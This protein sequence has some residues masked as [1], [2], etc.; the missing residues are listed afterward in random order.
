[1]NRG[2]RVV[3]VSH[4]G[5]IRSGN[6]DAGL[7]SSRVLAVADGM[8]GHA[9][10]EI[11]SGSVI[12]SLASQLNEVPTKA[13]DVRKWLQDCANIAHANVGDLIADNPDRRGMGTTLSAVIACEDRVVIGHVGD[14]RIYLWRNDSLTQITTD[15]TYVQLLVQQGQLTPDEAVHHPRRNLLMRAIDGIHE[16]EM[17]L[18]ELV[19]Q[20]GDRFLVCSDGLTGVV[21]DEHIARILAAPDLTYAASTLL[22]LALAAGAPD[23]VTVLIGH[24]DE[25]SVTTAPFLVGAAQAEDLAPRRTH[26]VR[27]R[28]VRWAFGIL[29]VAILASTL[30]A[31]WLGSQWFVGSTNGHVAIFRG[32][33]REIGPINFAHLYTETKYPVAVLDIVDQQDLLDGIA[34]GNLV[35]AEFA[36][37]DLLSR[38]TICT[39]SILGCNT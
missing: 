1:M 22:E 6:E 25:Q 21:G 34:V 8:G 3:A 23:N 7:A 2:F 37:Q 12:Q 10:G 19:V 9:A 14:S 36:I 24:Y 35:E 33:D 5:M 32:L 13:S 17:D 26:H 15:H 20:A 29:L 28:R 27:N 18:S 11:A 39:Q 31:R 16:V 30:S 38:S 4:V